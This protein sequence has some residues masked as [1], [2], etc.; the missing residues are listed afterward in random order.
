MEAVFA[1]EMP[2]VETRE[3]LLGFVGEVVSGLAHV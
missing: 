1:L 2:A 3:R